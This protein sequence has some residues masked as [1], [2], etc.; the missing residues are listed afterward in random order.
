MSIK[1]Q[2]RLQAGG[3]LEPTRFYIKREEGAT[4]WQLLERGEFCHLLAPSQSGKS[5]LAARA[6]S[7]LDGQGIRS[8]TIDLNRRFSTN[9]RA[10]D[11]YYDLF[12][13]IASKLACGEDF[14]GW[15]SGLPSQPWHGF[16]GD[17]LLP[18]TQSRIVVFLDEFDD[19][20]RAAFAED[21]LLQIRAL[22][23]ARAQSDAFSRIAFCLIGTLPSELFL[24]ETSRTAFNV[25]Q[26]ILLSDFT[27]KQVLE[28]VPL[29]RSVTPNPEKLVAEVYGLTRGHPYMLQKMLVGLIQGDR[30]PVARIRGTVTDLAGELF[31]PARDG[32]LTRIGDRISGPGTLARAEDK[33]RQYQT[34]RENGELDYRPHDPVQLD[35]CLA[36]AAVPD[37]REEGTFLLVRNQIISDHFDDSW[38]KTRFQQLYTGAPPKAPEPKAQ[39]RGDSELGRLTAKVDELFCQ[40]STD[41]D[42]PY[43]RLGVGTELIASTLYLFPMETVEVSERVALQVFVGIEGLGGQLW[44]QEVR[45]L[46]RLNTRRHP[47]LPTIRDG[48]YYEGDGKDEGGDG[49][50][51]LA[52]IVTDAGKHILAESGAMERFRSE[53][54]E[55]LRQLNLL[56]EGLAILHGGGLVHRNL[57]PGTVEVVFRDLEGKDLFLRMSRFE[58]APLIGNLLRRLDPRA[59]PD[60]EDPAG[61]KTLDAAI[62]AYFLDQG[63]EALAC[64]APERLAHILGRSGG[65]VFE[66]TNADVFSLGVIAYQWFVGQL[67]QQYLQGAFANRSYHPEPRQRLFE[68]MQR[69]IRRA[70]IH[71]RLRELLEKMLEENPRTRFQAAEV[72]DHLVRHFDAIVGR[73]EERDQ[74]H[75]Y[76]IAYLADEIG[77]FLQRHGFV[78]GDPRSPTGRAELHRFLAQDLS[79]PTLLFAPAGCAALVRNPD[80]RHEKSRY[81]LRGARLIYFTHLYEERTLQQQASHTVPQV[82]ITR[83]SVEETKAHHIN[84]GAVQ[85]QLPA[86]ELVSHQS[87]MLDLESRAKRPSWEPLLDSVERAAESPIQQS[88]L[89]ALDWLLRLNKAR[90]DAR[91]YPVDVSPDNPLVLILDKRRERDWLTKTDL[92]TLYYSDQRLRPDFASFF[93]QEAYKKGNLQLAFVPD[94][95]GTPDLVV[96]QFEQLHLLATASHSPPPFLSIA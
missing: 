92:G 7:Y 26:R 34:L 17:Y 43:R 56:A 4:L 96:R 36:G 79:H 54:V 19:L 85:R 13:D 42:S 84:S 10:D 27:K 55:A 67:P 86:T 30:L 75:R 77:G 20:T 45:A 11:F 59:R 47:T 62:R 57:H 89:D 91:L 3:A 5:T 14:G 80:D 70:P 9:L 49:K 71:E 44:E 15:W 1:D 69:R 83:F 23:N 73:W 31:S 35:L 21:F 87:S 94:T 25:G 88:F 12:R 66:G 95:G 8:V 90:F 38:I 76:L 37:R 53:K 82:L 74:D 32:V 29:M 93:E 81:V 2:D 52:Y 39:P 22:V 68:E 6:A 51:D 60:D 16:F 72:V 28:F 41:L 58:M 24:R 40:G 50:L 63:S 78:H 48:G 33:L 46:V 64:L 18:R 65:G 61:T